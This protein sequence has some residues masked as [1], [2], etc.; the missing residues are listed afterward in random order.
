MRKQSVCFIALVAMQWAFTIQAQTLDELNRFFKHWYTSFEYEKRH[1]LGMELKW[2][3]KKRSE[4][5]WALNYYPMTYL[6]EYPPF[7]LGIHEQFWG[8]DY[9]DFLSIA[10]GEALNIMMGIRPVIGK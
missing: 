1:T 2:R 9:H 8:S 3:L 7:M 6:D 4:V 5:Y 10:F